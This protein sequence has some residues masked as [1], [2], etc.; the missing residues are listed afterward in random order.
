MENP[1]YLKIIEENLRKLQAAGDVWHNT[2]QMALESEKENTKRE[3]MRLYNSIA[4]G[5]CLLAAIL[6]ILLAILTCQPVDMSIQGDTSG[7]FALPYDNGTL[8]LTHLSFAAHAKMPLYAAFTLAQAQAATPKCSLPDYHKG[9]D[10]SYQA[11][12]N[13]EGN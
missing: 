13:E 6:A 11:N 7:N 3:K 10:I 2:Q 9:I 4:V 1:K 8:E 12:K 5:G